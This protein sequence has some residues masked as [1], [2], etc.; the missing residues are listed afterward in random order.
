MKKLILAALAVTTVATPA[1]AAP[2]DNHD[3]GRGYQQVRAVD[4]DD[5][6]DR[7]YRGNR[8]FRGDQDRRFGR[9]D[10]H[11][12]YRDWRRG[13][14]FDR[15]YARGYREIRNP[16]FYRLREAPRGYRWVRSGN[17]AVLV[18]IA[19]GLVA[20]IMANMM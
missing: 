5:R 15:R 18:G 8:D 2:V 9:G 7:D 10:F 11:G 19:S 16:R 3:N 4:H 1:L 6:G 14:R 17:D 13:D 12:Q 20:A